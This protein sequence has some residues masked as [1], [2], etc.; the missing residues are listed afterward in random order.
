MPETAE[1]GSG[2][3]LRCLFCSTWNRIDVARAADRPKCGKCSKPMLLDRPVL[4]DDESFPRT[5]AESEVPVLVDFYADWCGPCKMMAPAVDQLAA[6]YAGKAIIAKVNTDLSQEA[7]RPFGIRG[8]PTTIVFVAGKEAARRS[9]AMP[10]Q[11][12]AQL[13]DSASP[14]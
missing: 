6:N 7:T 12:L 8:I 2:A 1:A 14:Q 10:Y 3:T 5:I 13:L 4:L 11:M 9:G